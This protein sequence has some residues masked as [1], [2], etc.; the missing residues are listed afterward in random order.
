MLQNAAIHVRFWVTLALTVAIAL[1]FR[2]LSERIE[3]KLFPKQSIAEQQL[4]VFGFAPLLAGHLLDSLM[5]LLMNTVLP[6]PLISAAA[7][8]GWGIVAYRWEPKVQKVWKLLLF[9]NLIP[10]VV[11]VLIC[12]QQ[13][14]MQRF[15]SGVVGAWSQLFYLPLLS[16]GSQLTRWSESMFAGFCASFALLVLGSLTGCVLSRRK[17]TGKKNPSSRRAVIWL[18]VFSIIGTWLVSMVALTVVAAQEV[19]DDLY[20]A[21][22]DYA[23]SVLRYGTLNDFYDDDYS[24]YG[25]QY[26]RPDFF[27]YQML[28]AIGTRLSASYHTVGHYDTYDLTTG[29]ERNKLIRNISFPMETAI[30]F[31]DGDG[32]L[33]HSSEDDVMYFGYYTQEE[34]DA[35]MDGTSGLHY[36]WIDISEGKHAEN[37]EDD[38]YLRFR[39][40]Y[41]GTHS[42]YDIKAMRVTGYFEGT[43]LVPVV[44]HYITETLI[45]PVVESEDSFSTGPNSYSY[46]VS[47]VD[48]TGKL[49]WQ[50]QFD[51]SAEYEGKDLVT[52]YLEPPDMWDYEE[53]SLVYG[54]REYENL[55]ALTKELAPPLEKENYYRR[56]GIYKLNDLLIFG[57]RVGADFNS[58]TYRSTGEYTAD[59]YL[60]TAIRSNPLACAMSALRNIYIVTGLLALVLLCVVRGAI[61]NR[62]IRPVAEVANA[63]QD[64]WSNIYDPENVPAPWREAEL[65]RMG[66]SSEQDRRRMKDNEIARLNTA[67]EYAKKAEQ[68]RRQMTSNIAH[69]LKTPLAVI[70]SYA[71]GLKEHIAEDKRD[72]YV[73]V[74]LTEAERTDG[75][76]LEMLDLSR[77][78][79]GKV[80]LSRDEFSLAELTKTVFEKLKMVAEVKALQISFEFPEQCTIV[81]DENRIAQVVE[82]FATNA[83]KYTPAGG[84]ITVRVQRNRAKTSF[85]IENDSE[86]LPREVLTKVWDTFYRADESRSGGG[87]GLGLAIAKNIVELHGGTCSV[88]NTKTGVEFGFTI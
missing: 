56:L 47:D 19:Y 68:N 17:R 21:G 32:N 67:L 26:E 69:E 46:I 38:P 28:Y 10:A 66:F 81:A 83:V 87:T 9:Q 78:E 50:L 75:L 57:M 62:L 23:D 7:V 88:R 51:R 20:E 16:L 36:G 22:Q 27:E 76:V 2:P 80:K 49:E 74:I 33:L 11:F 1:L 45:W 13:L 37:W 48:R 59:F 5:M 4:I 60:V 43:K 58:E 55:T 44:M 12:I 34:W 72:K 61:L 24:R 35:G 53:M 85:S 77:L 73:D 3:K 86:P 64:Q 52:V 25:Y 71:E 40:M 82:N 14:G 79:A 29:K 31:Y 39:T 30:L 84:Y 8:L 41:A 54:G 70:H 42:L 18:L 65:L 15:W 63:M 6:L